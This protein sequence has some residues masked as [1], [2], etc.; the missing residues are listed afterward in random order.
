MSKRPVYQEMTMI[1]CSAHSPA[2]KPTVSLDLATGGVIKT[3][4][5]SGTVFVR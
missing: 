5:G 2:K 4:G 3:V 1:L